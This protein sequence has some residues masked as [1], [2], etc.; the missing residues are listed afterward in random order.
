MFCENCGASITHGAHFCGGCGTKVGTL[1]KAVAPITGE[2][3]GEDNSG[4]MTAA[5]YDQAMETL[6]LL[7][8][9][10]L[11][12]QMDFPRSVAP[13]ADG[14]DYNDERLF[15]KS[16]L[17]DGI[18]AMDAFP[19]I[20]AIFDGYNEVIAGQS[21]IG[22]EV[23]AERQ[24]IRV[25]AKAV[26]LLQRRLG[27]LGEAQAQGASARQP[28]KAAVTMQDRHLSGQRTGADTGDIGPQ[29]MLAKA[30]VACHGGK[31]EPDEVSRIETWAGNGA[32]LSKL[33]EM[34][35]ALAARFKAA[36]VQVS[37]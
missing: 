8:K 13:I 33:E 22:N 11:P 17:P 26:H 36:C 23:R 20:S 16:T 29:D 34:D 10:T 27:E 19:V 18:E 4:A 21:V 24:E 32:S 28:R 2:Q 1:A 15:A 31:L 37:H 6:G 9:S 3:T 25:L 30:V 35:P 12:D 14:G 5:E 7:A